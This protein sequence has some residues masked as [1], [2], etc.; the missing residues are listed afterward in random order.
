MLIRIHPD[1]PADRQLN[2]VIECLNDGGVIIFPTDTIYAMGCDIFKSKAI[3]RVARIKGVKPEKA[4]FSFLC[5]DLSH[6]SDFTKP[7]NN[8]I[9]K[10]MKRTLPG[11]FT[12][13]LEA[14]NNVPKNPAPEKKNG[15]Y[16]G[17][18]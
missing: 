8:D 17:T 12:Y 15:W 1:N 13:I 18:R 6:L 2:M 11:P 5:H 14:N 16:Q 9:F 10:L 3:D 7:L 4:N